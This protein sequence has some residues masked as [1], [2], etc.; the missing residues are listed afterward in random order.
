[1]V[2]PGRSTTNGEFFSGDLKSPTLRCNKQLNTFA[3]LPPRFCDGINNKTKGLNVIKKNH[4]LHE[5]TRG[6][7][8]KTHFCFYRMERMSSRGRGFRLTSSARYFV[9]SVH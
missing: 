5:T 3:G 6:D 1:M 4:R 8:G 2:A 7:V 9:W